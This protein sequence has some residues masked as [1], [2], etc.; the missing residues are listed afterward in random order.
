[1]SP[2][3]RIG[4]RLLLRP[5]LVLAF[6]LAILPSAGADGGPDHYRVVGVAPG[7]SLILRAEPDPNAAS[8]GTVP[9][10]ARRLRNLG[11][12][13][14]PSL[15]EWERMTPTQ[16]EAARLRRWCRVGWQGVDG[17]LPGVHLVEDGG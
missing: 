15:L 2:E 4:S 6:L 14:G 11:C 7:A 12:Q 10:D 3:R 8:L 5:I 16:R 17:W 13:G 9:A 1:M